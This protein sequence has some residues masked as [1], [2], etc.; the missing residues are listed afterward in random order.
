VAPVAVTGADRALHLLFLCPIIALL[1]SWHSII[2]IIIIVIVLL[3]YGTS[4]F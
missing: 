4:A 3:I 1:I 2:I